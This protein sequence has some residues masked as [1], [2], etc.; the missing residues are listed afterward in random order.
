MREHALDLK[1]NTH[2]RIMSIAAIRARMAMLQVGYAAKLG[3]VN[4]RDVHFAAQRIEAV[5]G[6]DHQ[7]S[8]EMHGFAARLP[9]LRRHVPD[10]AAAGDRLIRAVERSTWPDANGRTDIHG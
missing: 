5:F 2:A 4:L 1:C 6:Q 9:D 8:G 7:L 10:L 3:A